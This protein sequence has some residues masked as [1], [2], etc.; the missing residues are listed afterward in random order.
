MR[1]M[2]FFWWNKEKRK[3]K[4]SLDARGTQGGLDG[5]YPFF[6]LVALHPRF[7]VQVLVV[8]HIIDLLAKITKLFFNVKLVAL[9]T[10]CQVFIAYLRLDLLQFLADLPQC[11]AEQVRAPLFGCL[12][13]GS[14]LGLQIFHHF[15]LKFEILW[16][17]C[18]ENGTT[19]ITSSVQ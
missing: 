7:F 11:F 3:L 19:H 15:I 4:S 10:K 14:L 12:L 8:L 9:G 18:N 17:D 5:A 6:A 1:W 13:L 16:H 2:V